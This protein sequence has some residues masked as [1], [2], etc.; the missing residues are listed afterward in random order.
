MLQ[1]KR[2]KRISLLENEEKSPKRSVISDP[3]TRI[4]P[5]SPALRVP[6]VGLF[7]CEQFADDDT[8]TVHVALHGICSLVTLGIHPLTLASLGAGQIVA[9]VSQRLAELVAREHH[10]AEVLQEEDVVGVDVLVHVVFAVKE[11]H[12][13]GDGR[14]QVSEEVCVELNSPRLR[15]SNV[16]E[17]IGIEEFAA[18]PLARLRRPVQDSQQVRVIHVNSSREIEFDTTGGKRCVDTVDRYSK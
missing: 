1:K 6:V 5:P 7:S 11:S 16:V 3:R 14:H 12:G 15:V 18:H 9:R 17:K 8:Q 4:L 2:K 10:A 13:A